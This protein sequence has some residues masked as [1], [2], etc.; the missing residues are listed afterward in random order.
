MGQKYM[1]ATLAAVAVSV[2]AL[3]AAARA[4]DHS[5]HLQMLQKKAGA[6]DKVRITLPDTVLTDQDGNTRRFKTDAIAGRLVAINFIY[7]TCTTVCPVQS[8][9]FADVQKRLGEHAG[10]DVVLLSVTVDPVRDTPLVLKQFASRYHAGPG[11][12]F[13]TGST[14]AVEEV[15]KAFDVYIANFDDHPATIVIGDPGSGDWMRFFGFPSSAQIVG[16]LQELQRARDG[17]RSARAR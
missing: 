16:R 11:W 12:K 6:P 17:S 15:L 13:L 1:K 3:S 14:Q 9:L 2:L 4:M 8:A 5:R 10:E 7:T